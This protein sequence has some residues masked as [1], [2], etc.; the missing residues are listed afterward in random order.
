MLWV[1]QRFPWE[2]LERT[3]IC[4]VNSVD[5]VLSYFFLLPSSHRQ[6][7]YLPRTAVTK[8]NK[9]G[10]LKQCKSIGSWFWMLGVHDQGVVRV[11]SFRGIYSVPLPWLLVVCWFA[12]L[13]TIF[14]FPWHLEAS[15]RSL[16]SSS[17]GIVPIVCVCYVCLYVC[18]Q[19]SPFY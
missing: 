14:G 3:R 15:F 8:Y 12:G 5:P 11:D 9:L 10:G 16:P 17:Q 13:L 18:I 4:H 1:S 2:C 19:I 6:M 7:C